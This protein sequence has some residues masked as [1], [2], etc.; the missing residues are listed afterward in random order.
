VSVQLLADLFGLPVNTFIAQVNAKTLKISA[1]DNGFLGQYANAQEALA[2][3]P[4]AGTGDYFYNS[5]TGTAWGYNAAFNPPGF[6]NSAI[7]AANYNTLT[8]AQKNGQ[9]WYIY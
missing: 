6:Q 2:A 4:N 8:Q 1:G 7:T 9:R 3:H 5:T